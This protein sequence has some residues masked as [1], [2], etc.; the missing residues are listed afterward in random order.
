MTEIGEKRRIAPAGPAVCN[1][2][3]AKHSSIVGRY[4]ALAMTYEL[5]W[6]RLNKAI[7]TKRFASLPEAKRDAHQLLPFY[8]SRF[9]VTR[10]EIWGEKG[11]VHAVDAGLAEPQIQS[12]SDLPASA[13]GGLSLLLSEPDGS[14]AG[15][16]IIKTS[17]PAAA[18]ATEQVRATR[19]SA[20]R[21]KTAAWRLAGTGKR[22]LAQEPERKPPVDQ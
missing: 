17:V 5:R 21:S 13:R 4:A 12:S 3:S 14:A 18:L 16:R 20:A 22:L 7:E 10:A 1:R 9:A 8:R 11:P 19:P 15:P 2:R 6:L